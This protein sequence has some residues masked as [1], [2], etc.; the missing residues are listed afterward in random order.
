LKETIL[1]HSFFLKKKRVFKE[2]KEI[3]SC[4]NSKDKQRLNVSLW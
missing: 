2:D 3:M 1:V 4:I